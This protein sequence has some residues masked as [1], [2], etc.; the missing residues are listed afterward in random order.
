MATLMGL[1]PHTRAAQGFTPGAFPTDMPQCVTKHLNFYSVYNYHESRRNGNLFRL[2]HKIY[3][4]H[5]TLWLP[6]PARLCVAG[7][8]KK[9]KRKKEYKTW[10]RGK[11]MGDCVCRGSVGVPTARHSTNNSTAAHQN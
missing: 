8:H 6:I 3:H 2:P 5:F 10:F 1:L 4:A 9:G 7:K 11:R